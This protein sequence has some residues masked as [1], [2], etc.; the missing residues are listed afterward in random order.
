M[1][2]DDN[3]LGT[4]LITLLLSALIINNFISSPTMYRNFMFLGYGLEA[5][6]ELAALLIF[7]AS[8][9]LWTIIFTE[10]PIN[11]S[12]SFINNFNYYV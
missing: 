6:R 12:E 7:I 9:S 1:I 5:P 10:S 11:I 3:F 8:T 2:F 4:S